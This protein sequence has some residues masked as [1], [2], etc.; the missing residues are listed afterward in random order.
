MDHDE[1]SVPNGLGE[2]VEMFLNAG[3]FRARVTSL[4]P[5]DKVNFFQKER[6]YP[7]LA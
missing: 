2:I 6:R 3:Y 5:F 4:S 1:E 7:I